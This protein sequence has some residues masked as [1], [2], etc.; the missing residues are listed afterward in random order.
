MPPK[1][2]VAAAV[3]PKGEPVVPAAV[4]PTA[5]VAPAVVPGWMVWSSVGTS[6]TLG[7]DTADR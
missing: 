2:V 1:P 6:Y 5:V 7:A 3:V 4:V